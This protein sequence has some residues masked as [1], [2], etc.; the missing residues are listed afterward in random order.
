MFNLKIVRFGITLLLVLW[1][2]GCSVAE[3]TKAVDEG[4]KVVAKI[5]DKTITL[6]EF[7]EKLATVPPMSARKFQGPEGRKEF[8]DLLVRNELMFL[9]AQEI[10]I[11]DDEDVI[12][13]ME[14]MKM[15]VVLRKYYTA[16][17]EENAEISDEEVENYYA[18]H[19]DEFIE[20]AKVKV[21]QIV[22]SSEENA[23]KVKERLKKGESF[24][25]IARNESIDSSTAKRDGVL[26]YIAENNNYVPYVGKSEEFQKAAFELEL[27]KL[28]DPIETSKG[29]HIIEILERE[30]QR[31]KP[32]SEVRDQIVGNL[33]PKKIEEL[34]NTLTTSLKEK[35]N[36]EYFEENLIEKKSPRELFDEAQNSKDPRH[37]LALYEEIVSQFP[38]S[39]HG[40]KAQFMVGFVYS[41]QLNDKDKARE[42][43]QKVIDQYP[44]SELADDA[45][46]MIE[47]MD[48]PAVLDETN[49]LPQNE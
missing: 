39:E 11:D 2:Y 29:F 6:Q 22:C 32:L 47:N 19:Q 5:G 20:A 46:W 13:Q 14:D 4:H 10:G 9:H 12:K 30:E 16:E 8:L 18:T 24:E 35:Y 43:F 31:V 28:S 33:R 3:E 40:Y 17:V 21:R 26:G 41:E 44:D 38:D 15:R 7:E 25:E 45:A 48:K 23:K 42:A 27:N 34:T 37:A 36:Y 49:D 1:A